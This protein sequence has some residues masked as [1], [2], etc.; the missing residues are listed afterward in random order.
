MITAKSAKIELSTERKACK[1]DPTS[2]AC[3]HF[4]ILS[5]DAASYEGFITA[6]TI[7][8]LEHTAYFSA[9]A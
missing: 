1:A 2:D 6:K 4:N 5:L 3:V 7:D 8:Y 9:K